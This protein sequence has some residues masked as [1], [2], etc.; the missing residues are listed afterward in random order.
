MTARL[1]APTLAAVLGQIPVGRHHAVTG[2]QIAARLGWKRL[3]TIGEAVAELREQGIPICATSRDGY[4]RAATA[5]GL[6]V[7]LR[8]VERR[9][10]SMLRQ[11][12]M[13]RAALLSMRGQLSLSSGAGVR[14][15][16]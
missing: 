15:E 4:W 6:E 14:E 12:R 5:E 3:R 8:E 1:D 13:L 9:A 7:S 2:Q 16:T 11:R 10:R